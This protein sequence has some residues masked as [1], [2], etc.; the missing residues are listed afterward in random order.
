MHACPI[1]RR[2]PA[3]SPLPQLVDFVARSESHGY[4]ILRRLDQRHAEQG[5]EPPAG[6]DLGAGAVGVVGP[7]LSGLKLNHSG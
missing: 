7:G 5:R 4:D 6:L 3:G 2:A 1:R